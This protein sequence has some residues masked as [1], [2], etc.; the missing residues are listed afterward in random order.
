M[1]KDADEDEKLILAFVDEETPEGQSV[2]KLLKKVVNMNT[3]Y[4]DKLEI[5]LIDPDEFPLMI[6]EWEKMFDIEIEAGPVLGLADISEREGLWFDM[7]QLNLVDPKK[8]EAQNVE[9]LDAWI[10]QIMSGKISLE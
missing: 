9:V 3:Q 4:A 8:Y 6:D 7:D 5:I 1:K 2:F 10:D